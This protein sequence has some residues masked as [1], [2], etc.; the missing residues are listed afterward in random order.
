MHCLDLRRAFE[1]LAAAKTT[2][3]NIFFKPVIISV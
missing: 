1:S 2:I 3:G